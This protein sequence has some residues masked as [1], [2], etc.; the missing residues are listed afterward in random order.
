MCGYIVCGSN[1]SSIGPS[2]FFGF[3][4]ACRLLIQ[5]HRHTG[6][7]G[8]WNQSGKANESS[9]VCLCV[10]APVNNVQSGLLKIYLYMMF[11]M[12]ATQSM[13][14]HSHT[15]ERARERESEKARET[16]LEKRTQMQASTLHPTASSDTTLLLF[17]S[18]ALGYRTHIEPSAVVCVCLIS[19]N[20]SLSLSIPLSLSLSLCISPSAT[21]VRAG[22]FSPSLSVAVSLNDSQRIEPYFECSL[23]LTVSWK[24]QAKKTK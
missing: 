17:H 13:S 6:M 22:V 8:F 24:N 19:C 11:M 3:R 1:R 23:S 21:L 16:P 14:A 5:A 18:F 9:A 15:R 20:C 7:C 4:F 12:T 10:C 2:T